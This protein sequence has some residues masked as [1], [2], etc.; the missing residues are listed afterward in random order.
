MDASLGGRNL[1][2][3]LADLEGRLAD[4]FGMLNQLKAGLKI[5]P[6]QVVEKPPELKKLEQVEAMG[7]PLWEGGLQ[8][9]PHI[10]LEMV[11]VMHRIRKRFE[12]LAKA[13][14]PQER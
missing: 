5:R 11:G 14:Q 8:D 9:Q 3:L 10:W 2:G 4:F 13:S 1:R 7:L 12:D 6:D